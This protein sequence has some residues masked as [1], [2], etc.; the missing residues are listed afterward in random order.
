MKT[1]NMQ[2]KQYQRLIHPDKFEMAQGAIK[3]RAHELSS[4]ANA[5]YQILTNDIDRAEYLI[6]LNKGLSHQGSQ[7]EKERHEEEIIADDPELVERI[8]ELRMTIAESDDL[9]ELQE[10][11]KALERDYNEELGKLAGTFSPQVISGQESSGSFCRNFERRSIINRARYLIKMRE[12][13]EDREEQIKPQSVAGINRE[14]LS[15]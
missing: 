1:L 11:K 5:A 9:E 14:E 7:D 3:D 15:D 13:V 8:F 12:E 10:I 6:R 2:F 4:F